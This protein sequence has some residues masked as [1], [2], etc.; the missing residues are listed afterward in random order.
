[1]DFSLSP[2]QDDLRGLTRRILT[3]ACTPEHLVEVSRRDDATD[4]E[5]WH[6][7]G[8]A[9]LIAIGLPESVGGGGYGWLESAIVLHEIGRAAAPVPGLAVIALAAPALVDHPDLL[10]GVADGSVVV[11]AAVHEPVGDP[12]TPSTTGT[13]ATGGT[14]VSGTK[15]C[16]PHGL[17]ATR[18]VVTTDDGLHVVE[19]SARGVTVERQ[20]TT[21]GVPDAM[22]TFDAAPS[23]RVGDDAARDDLLRRGL[24]AATLMTAGACESAL[25]LTSS[26]AVSRTQF[27]KPIAAFQ[28]VSQRAGD[29]YIDTEAVRLTAW[30]AAWRLANGHP[31][32]DALLSAKFWSAEGGWRVVHAAHHVHGGVGV[33]RDYPL[34]RY[35]LLHK[36][37]ELLLGSA[38]P[39]LQRL[40]RLLADTP[41]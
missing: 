16:V 7:L 28:A 17:L 40:G 25:A 41:A 2:D 23:V 39:T 22:V 5:L 18:F 37:L 15:V 8:D 1:M 9:G 36:Q 21:T 32:D 14:T 11:S 6:A 38:T 19:A 34:H 26:Y 33:D 10:T 13:S 30:H 20:D 24:S 31:A 3:D 12:W 35:F 4:L 29:A 27:D